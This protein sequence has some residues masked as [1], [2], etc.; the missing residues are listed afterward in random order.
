M[1]TGGALIGPEAADEIER[2]GELL[3]QEIYHGQEK[4]DEIERLR[5]DRD[6]YKRIAEEAVSNLEQAVKLLQ[7]FQAAVHD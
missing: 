4:L 5:A 1:H 2:L 7:T 3:F 6:H